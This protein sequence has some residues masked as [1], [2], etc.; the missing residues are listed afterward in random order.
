M[1]SY[2]SWITERH[3]PRNWNAARANTTKRLCKVK[4]IAIHYAEGPG[5]SPSDIR[6]TFIDKTSEDIGFR[7][8]GHPGAGIQFIVGDS[9]TLALAPDPT[10]VFWQIGDEWARSA[11]ESPWNKDKTTYPRNTNYYVIGIEHC[12]PLRNGKFTAATLK[13]S[14]Q[15]V[16]WIKSEYGNDLR[17]GR[18]Y[19]FSGKACPIWFSPVIRW[20]ND[21]PPWSAVRR[22]YPEGDTVVVE[23]RL[24]ELRWLHLL[25]YYAQS[26]AN[27]IP[28]ELL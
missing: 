22:H 7:S 28:G 15:L 21:W 19:D 10:Y 4:A 25:A 6:D 11:K 3:M 27:N 18:H 5:Q 1:A 17:I 9:E 12:H 2:P 13:R 20:S 23:K 16:R 26:N 24:K 8:Q 14:H